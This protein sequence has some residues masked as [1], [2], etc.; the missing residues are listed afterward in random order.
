MRIIVDTSTVLA[1]LLSRGKNY[2][3]YIFDLVKQ[4]KITLITC[5]EAIQELKTTGYLLHSIAN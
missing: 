1:H 4:K 5:K 3:T 2:T